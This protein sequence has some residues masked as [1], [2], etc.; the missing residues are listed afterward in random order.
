MLRRLVRCGSRGE[1]GVSKVLETVSKVGRQSEY[2][3][4]L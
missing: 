4:G 2:I 3:Y 1:V